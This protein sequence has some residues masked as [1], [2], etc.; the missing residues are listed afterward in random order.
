MRAKKSKKN[1]KEYVSKNAI[2]IKCQF[3]EINQTCN[4]R[5]RKE[6]DESKH[7]RTFCILTPNKSK[8][9]VEK[10]TKSGYGK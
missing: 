10:M 2:L 7:I 1:F 6:R 4:K 8:K 3:C 9:T 5:D